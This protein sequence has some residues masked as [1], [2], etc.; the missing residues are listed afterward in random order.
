MFSGNWHDYVGAHAGYTDEEQEQRQKSSGINKL[1]HVSKDFSRYGNLKRGDEFGEKMARNMPYALDQSTF[2]FSEWNANEALVDN[3]KPIA[4]V[5]SGEE[6]EYIEDAIKWM[7][8]DGES[9]EDAAPGKMGQVFRLSEKFGV[10]I[11]GEDRNELWS[12]E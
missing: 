2:H 11:I 8:E 3:W 9:R 4:I 7:E 12:P 1:P 5:V 10:P 6:A